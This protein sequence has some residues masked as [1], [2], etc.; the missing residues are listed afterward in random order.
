[1]TC[2]QSSKREKR[3]FT[4]GTSER[5]RLR[6]RWTSA[7]FT[8]LCLLMPLPLIAKTNKESRAESKKDA[9]PILWSNPGDIASR[10]LF[11][12]PGGQAHEPNTRYTFVKEDFEGTSPKFEI[13]DENG[14]KWKA[15]LGPEAKP[16]TVA[17]RLRWAAGDFTNEDYFGRGL[18]VENMQPLKRGQKL[19]GPHG[20]MPN[21]RL[22]RYLKGEKTIG[23]WQ[24]RKNPFTGTRE[25]NGLRVMMALIN[26]WDLKDENN[27]AY[28]RK[29]TDKHISL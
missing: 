26:N 4:M 22:K 3:S 23:S 19:I 25:L 1:M 18:Q 10:D 5:Q 9:T 11:Y 24:W 27:S 17:S 14:T 13:S 28:E 6:L 21:A 8:L 16:E 29:D 2:Y 7:M 15:K 20:T 12:G